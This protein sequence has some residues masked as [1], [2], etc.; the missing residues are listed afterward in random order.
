VRCL[1]KE[2]KRSG[3][4]GSPWRSRRT[5]GSLLNHLHGYNGI[6]PPD[7]T[8]KSL[9]FDIYR[10]LHKIYGGFPNPGPV[11]GNVCKRLC[12]AGPHATRHRFKVNHGPRIRFHAVL[13]IRRARSTPYHPSSNGMVVRF[14][15]S[16]HAGLYH[17]VNAAH[18]YWDEVLPFFLM[19]YRATPITTG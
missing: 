13:G 8:P 10:S 11:R 19:A 3:I 4:Y 1:S 7:S 14:H 15:W 16:L 18:T 5:S 12:Q 2:E 17:Y 9:Q 6:L